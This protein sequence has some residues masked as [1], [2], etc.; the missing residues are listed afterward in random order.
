MT[1]CPMHG[2]QRSCADLQE[3]IYAHYVVP[4]SGDTAL[5]VAVTSKAKETPHGTRDYRLASLKHRC[6]KPRRDKKGQPCKGL[7]RSPVQ[8][9]PSLVNDSPLYSS[10]RVSPAVFQLSPGLLD[11]H[12]LPSYRIPGEDDGHDTRQSARMHGSAV[13]HL[14]PTR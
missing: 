4:K 7:R 6:F 3:Q 14:R 1:A 2:E 9:I 12:A 11:A 5:Q 13:Y 8:V 10:D